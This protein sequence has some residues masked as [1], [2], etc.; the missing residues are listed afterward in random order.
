MN[1][2]VDLFISKA[3]QWQEETTKL[4]NIILDCGLTE[5]LK[6]YKPCYSFGK[7]NIVIIQGF[8]HYFALMFFK[9]ALLN[10]VHGI[11]VKP[12]ENSQ[13]ARQV[14][15]TNV[16]EIE[17]Q[18]AILKAY[19][20]EAIEVEKAGLKVPWLLSGSQKGQLLLP[21]EFTKKLVENPMLRA[22]FEALTPGRQKA[23]S[24]YFSAPKQSKTREA[25][26]EKYVQHI[27]EGK[28]INDDYLKSR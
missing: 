23:Y 9:G 11:M 6:W 20:Y 3:T 14:R 25:R 10:D 18:E 15:F 17:Q 13:S 28:G 21:D 1:P 4:R 19:I 2:K 5:D 26:I 27:L 16:H 12:G 22:A 8:K 7:S 24:L